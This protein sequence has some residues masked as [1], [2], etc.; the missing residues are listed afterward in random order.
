MRLLLRC[1]AAFF[2]LIAA[3]SLVVAALAQGSPTIAPDRQIL[4]MVRHPPDHFRP[5][6][7]YGGNYGDDIASSARERLARR[8]A[9]DHDLTFVDGWP[10]PMIGVD[11]F[12]M[13]VPAGHSTSVAAEELAH[14][15]KVAWAEPVQLYQA[16]GGAASPN[17]PLYPAQP[18]SKD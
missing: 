15:S 6:T 2:A 5:N 3:P 11:C 12:I 14:D 10:M 8:I 18:V 9:R 17:D 16:Q 13:A 7:S 1:V 4:V